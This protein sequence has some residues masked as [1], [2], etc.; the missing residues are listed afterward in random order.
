VCIYHVFPSFIKENQISIP[1]P[2]QGLRFISTMKHSRLV[3]AEK[4]SNLKFFTGCMHFQIF[5]KISVQI[6]NYGLV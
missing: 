1:N 2:K 3:G 5:D 4:Q 6:E